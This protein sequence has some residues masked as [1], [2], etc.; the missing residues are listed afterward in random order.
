VNGEGNEWK[1]TTE[2][3][4]RHLKEEKRKKDGGDEPNQ[5]TV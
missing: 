3:C 1:Y 5:D 4:P 2:N